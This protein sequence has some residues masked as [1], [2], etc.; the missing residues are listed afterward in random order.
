MINPFIDENGNDRFPYQ[1]LK[2]LVF[3]LV[4]PE[5]E[6]INGIII[7]EEYRREHSDEY[8]IVVG[9]GK[10]VYVKRFKRY[11]PTTVKVGDVVIYDCSIPYNMMIKDRNG[12]EH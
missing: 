7:P 6:S 11:I 8:G 3:V 10:G 4:V 1:P 12:V 9:V 2:A 5:L